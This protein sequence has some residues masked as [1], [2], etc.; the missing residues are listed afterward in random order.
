MTL[1]ETGVEP[2][3]LLGGH[4]RAL[5]R[6]RPLEQVDR[7]RVV[8]TGL[9]P[10]ADP[11]TQVEVISLKV[12]SRHCPDGTLLRRV[13]RKLQRGENPRRSAILQREPAVH[14]LFKSVCPELV[15]RGGVDQPKIDPNTTTRCLKVALDHCVDLESAN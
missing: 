9:M 1:G 14:R 6:N 13:Q 8:L 15:A 7:D 3:R 10:H 12:L 5:Q 4:L 2:E 11:A